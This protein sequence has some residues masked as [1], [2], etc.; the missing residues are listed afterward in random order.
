MDNNHEWNGLLPDNVVRASDYIA[1]VGAPAGSTAQLLFTN[2]LDNAGN[3]LPYDTPNGL[4]ALASQWHVR[5]PISAIHDQIQLRKTFGRHTFSVG[6][7]LANY[8][9]DNRWFFTNI[10]T[11]IRDNPRFLDLVVTPPGGGD[12]I[13]V[14]RNGF[15]NFLSYYINGV[16]ETSVVSGVVGGEVQLTDQLRADLG[17]RVEYNDFLQR[18]E[19]TARQ[20]LDGD[21][22]TTKFDNILYGTNRFRNF[23]KDLTDWS[24]SVGLNYVVN[25]N[26]ALFGAGS[27]GYKMPSLDD[28]VEL[29]SQQRVNLL[30]AQEVYSVEGGV[31]AQFGRAAF[32][33]NGFYTELRNLL[34][35]GAEVDPVTNGTIWV[36][37]DVPDNRSYGTEL[38]ALYSPVSGLQLQGNAT[39]MEA[40]VA[41]GGPDSLAHLKGERLSLAPST[42][43]NL[44]AL[45][46]PEALSALQFRADF[47]WVG[48][49]F[50]EAPE[51][52]NPEFAFK[53]P[54][55]T[56][57]NFGAGYTFPDA[58][59]RLNVDL[60]NAF[61]SKGLEEGNPR[62]AGTGFIE[63]FV[64][65]P[66]LPRRLQ[67][68]LT[69]NF[70]A[71]G[72][73]PI[74]TGQMQ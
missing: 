29:T 6:A 40:E 38:E 60:L 14:T 70:G 32:T 62:L 57:F 74:Q 47:H 23:T 10:L 56:Y 71:G 7:Y 39:I 44:A 72:G 25:D 28:L 31:K 35:Q 8:T 37:R 26:L 13:E 48:E 27:R 61:Q 59:L 58:G 1:G 3:R 54:A 42:I 34:S 12:T 22:V 33:V 19:I 67:V 63:F 65:R 20:D 21:T 15:R 68:A 64:A 4:V 49:R 73:I 24:A 11:D 46:S 51:R 45:F 36:V 69:Y 50:S 43:G 66:I 53:L 9:Q 52:R 30:E 55:Y 17:V 41:G 2:H 16:G 18:P 5:K